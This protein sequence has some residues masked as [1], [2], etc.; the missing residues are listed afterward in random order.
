MD[1]RV[2]DAA[3]DQVVARV[4][5]DVVAMCRCDVN[6]KCTDEHNLVTS[7][8]DGLRS[9]LGAEVD[10]DALRGNREIERVGSIGGTDHDGVEAGIDLVDVVARAPHEGV[11]ARVRDQGIVAVPPT[12]LLAPGPATSKS[13]PEPPRSVSLP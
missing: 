6:I 10:G 5:R 1:G 3:V 7:G 11:V 4:G 8:V 13:L 2:A 12:R 9:V